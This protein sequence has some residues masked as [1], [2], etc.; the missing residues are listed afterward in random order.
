M[1][2]QVWAIERSSVIKKALMKDIVFER[3]SM[4]QKKTLKARVFVFQSVGGDEV[5]RI[6]IS[7]GGNEIL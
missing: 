7:V 4:Y 1:K 3:E 5:G 6:R 2:K